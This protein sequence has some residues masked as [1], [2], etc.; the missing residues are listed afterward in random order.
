[1][2]EPTPELSYKNEAKTIHTNA[3]AATG[4]CFAFEFAALTIR[5]GASDELDGGDQALPEGCIL[6]YLDLDL[7]CHG[8]IRCQSRGQL[9]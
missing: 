1:M 4:S 8:R 5:G 9:L 7:Y 2:V 3:L 6:E